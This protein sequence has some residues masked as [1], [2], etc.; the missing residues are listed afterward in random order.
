MVIHDFDRIR[1]I[2]FP[3]KT[4]SPLVI[5]SNAVLA[6]A[7]TTQAFQPVTR[8]PGQVSQTGGLIQPVQAAFRLCLD[9]VESSYPMAFIQLLRVLAFKSLALQNN[10]WVGSILTPSPTGR[11]LG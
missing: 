9:T 1:S 4:N 6:L 10:L 7:V 3:D 5:D 8:Q 2:V 11:G